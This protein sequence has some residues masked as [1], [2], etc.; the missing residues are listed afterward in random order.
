M[1]KIL[2]LS[3]TERIILTSENWKTKEN[4]LKYFLLKQECILEKIKFDMS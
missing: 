3:L 4:L 2:E 1:N